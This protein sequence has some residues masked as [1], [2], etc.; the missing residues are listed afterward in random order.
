VHNLKPR[1]LLIHAEM[2]SY[3]IRLFDTLSKEYDTTF[4]FMAGRNWAAQFPE[5][6]QWKY[7]NLKPYPMIGYSKNFSPGLAYELVK[8][9]CAYDVI[10][11]SEL[12]SFATHISFIVAKIL[13]KKFIIWAEDWVWSRNIWFRIALPYVRYIVRHANACIIAGTKSRDFFISLGVQPTKLF[14]AP[15]C[16]VDFS[17]VDVDFQKLNKLKQGANPHNKIVISYLSRVVRY[18]ALDLLIRVFARLERER[19]DVL[20]LILGDGSFAPECKKL[21][22]DLKVKN[23]FWPQYATPSGVRQDPLSQYEIAYYYHLS[24]I[25]VLPGRFMPN[26]NVPCESWGIAIVEALS[27]GI[28]TISTTSVAAAHDLLDQSYLAEEGN[29]ESLLSKLRLVLSCSLEDIGERQRQKL[30]STA[31]YQK[32]LEG[33]QGAISLSMNDIA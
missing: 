18:K 19:D 7:K 1:I 23:F 9:R 2:R 24:D 12:A 4:L 29:E 30:H 22:Q 20:L 17:K 11:S 13:R 6:Q 25:F 33:F 15:H 27:L 16:A 5:S 8:R 32:M 28:P 3:R 14:A 31:T 10:I 21:M 26:E